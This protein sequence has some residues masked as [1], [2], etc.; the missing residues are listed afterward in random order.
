MIIDALLT[1]ADAQ[2][3]TTSAASTDYVDTISAGDA[4]GNEAWLV[5]RVDTAFT[6]NT[7]VPT[8]TFQLQTSPATNFTDSGTATLVQSAA[9]LAS[10]LTAGKHWLVKIPVNTLRYLRVYKVVS[11]NTGADYVTAGKWDAFIVKDPSVFNNKR[12]LL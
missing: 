12:Y 7:T 8:F 3:G 5:V 11:T 6:T 9:F 1:F 2:T 4:I 10:Q